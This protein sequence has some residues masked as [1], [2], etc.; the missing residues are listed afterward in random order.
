MLNQLLCKGAH[1]LRAVMLPSAVLMQLVGCQEEH[2]PR[3]N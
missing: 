3:K 2:L 1:L